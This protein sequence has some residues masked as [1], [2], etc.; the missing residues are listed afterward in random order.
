VLAFT[1]GWFVL[2]ARDARACGGCFHEQ[3]TVVVDTSFVTDHRMVFSMSPKQTVL[4]DQVRYSGSPKDFAWVLPVKPGARIEMS[5][6]AWIAALDT[7]TQTVITGPTPPVCP[8]SGG[9]T[10]ID[11][12]GSGRAPTE[13]TSGAP[14]S[15]GCGGGYVGASGGVDTYDVPATGTSGT[16]ASPAGAA[17]PSKEV[18]EV[19]SQ[20]VVGPYESVTVHSTQ[21]EALGDW[22]RANGYDLPASVQPT[23]DAYSNHG[24]DFIA[25]KLAPTVG[26]QA[27]QPVRVITPGADPTL[28]L[29]MVAAGVG[30]HVGLELYVL[31]E[32]RY[33]TANFPDAKVDFSQLAW[34]PIR[35]RSNYT[36]LVQQ[37][38]AAGN[39]TAWLTESSE[40]V[41]LY[42]TGSGN[43]P[44]ASLYQST[45]RTEV[46]V[47]ACAPSMGAGPSSQEGGSDGAPPNDG[48]VVLDGASAVD[49]V[50]VDQPDAATG[51]GA[52]AD[53]DA[54]SASPAISDAGGCGSPVVQPCD[55]LSVAMVGIAT[56]N[57][58]VTRLRADFPASALATDL[59][60]EATASQTPVSSQH[61]TTAYTIRNYSPCPPASTATPAATSLPVDRSSPSP[62]YDST[63]G[64]CACR[65]QRD[66]HAHSLRVILWALGAAAF[67][68]SLRRRRRCERR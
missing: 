45:C 55:D 28:P 34:D 7:T 15:G 20:Q 17:G 8:P 52:G 33:H 13:Y 6:D 9:I 47:P 35:G 39:G 38:L 18:V 31:S 49:A 56:G 30:A 16:S 51:D 5:H 26:I 67:A 53:S 3:P 40:L 62:R 54:G 42:G 36:E 46:F 25:L 41:D 24:F 64:G 60:L 21:G 66:A 11:A 59:V 63:S 50:A 12:G 14:S 68:F 23:I 29:R 58:W 4:W 22:L 48:A 57:L 43:A 65:L 2:G 19:I 61:E 32:G 1:G 44:L 27:M 10:K 37:A